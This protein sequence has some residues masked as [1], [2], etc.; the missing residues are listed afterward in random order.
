MEKVQSPLKKALNSSVQSQLKDE[1][2]VILS[3][4]NGEIKNFLEVS[5]GGIC[6]PERSVPGSTD[7][8]ILLLIFL[9]HG[10]L[11]TVNQ[12]QFIPIESCH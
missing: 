2:F 10:G 11:I 4:N 3:F 1:Q 6:D 12:L 9:V 7:P 5:L 8:K